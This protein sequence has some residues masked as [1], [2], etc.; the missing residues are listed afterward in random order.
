MKKIISEVI[1]TYNKAEL[2][3]FLDSMKRV[4]FNFGAKA[5]LSVAMTD[6]KTPPSKKSNS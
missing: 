5:G 3:E 4:G 2:R 1:E 6:V